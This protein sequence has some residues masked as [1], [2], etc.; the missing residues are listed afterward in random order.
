MN[1]DGNYR[2]VMDRLAE[3]QAEAAAERLADPGRARRRAVG[4]WEGRPASRPSSERLLA[5]VRRRPAR[6]ARVTRV[7]LLGQCDP[8]VDV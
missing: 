7:R 8:Q 2:Q 4:G 6:T 1:P 3:F 5:L